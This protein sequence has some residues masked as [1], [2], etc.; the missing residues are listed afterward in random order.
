MQS[1]KLRKDIK[2]EDIKFVPNQLL[3]VD[4]NSQS[5]ILLL[6]ELHLAEHRSLISRNQASKEQI[7]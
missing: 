3:A 6:A 7:F 2:F 1:A 4:K 5:I